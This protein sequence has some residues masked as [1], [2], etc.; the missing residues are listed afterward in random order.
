MNHSHAQRTH[1]AARIQ[2]IGKFKIYFIDKKNIL[3]LIIYNFCQAF[4]K[5]SIIPLS[6]IYFTEVPKI[7]L[8]YCK[9]TRAQGGIFCSPCFSS[10]FFSDGIPEWIPTYGPTYIQC[11]LQKG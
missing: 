6:N 4:Y 8:A 10:S 3:L 9:M 2:H 5:K 7:N 11:C 1:L